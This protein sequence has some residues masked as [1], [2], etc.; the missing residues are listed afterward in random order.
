MIDA[1]VRTILGTKQNNLEFRNEG[2]VVGTPSTVTAVNFV[3]ASVT[4]SFATGVVTVAVPGP[5]AVTVTGS[6]G[7]NAALAS[8]L[9]ALAARG[10]IIDGTTA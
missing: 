5:V 4:A 3:G 2:I 7:G 8:L 10:I 9:T 6:R 1:D